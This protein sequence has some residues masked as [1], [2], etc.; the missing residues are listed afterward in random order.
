MTLIFQVSG[1]KALLGAG[2]RLI[3][4]SEARA[5]HYRG[6]NG[7]GYRLHWFSKRIHIEVG[8]ERLSDNSTFTVRVAT[9]YR[10]RAR[11]VSTILN[12]F[13]GKRGDQD[14]NG[15]TGDRKHELWFEK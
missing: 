7:D 9:S 14:H 2:N 12:H 13:F 8:G 3:L 4:A 1:R 5:H 15:I 10:S 6:I 11:K